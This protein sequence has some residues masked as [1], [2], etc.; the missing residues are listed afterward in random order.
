MY[1]LLGLSAGA[2]A[3]AVAAFW[4]TLVSDPP[5]TEAEAIAKFDI[6]ETLKTARQD[7]SIQDASV[8]GCAYVLK[9]GHRCD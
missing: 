8:I 9:D 1:K 4:A 6:G 5:K 7:A 2:I 3:L